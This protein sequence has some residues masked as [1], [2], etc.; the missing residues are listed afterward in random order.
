MKGNTKLLEVLNSLLADEL[1]AINQYIV[2][3]EMCADW[4]Y[5]KLHEHFEKRSKDEMRHA[6]KLIERLLFLEGI[7]IVSKL[8][9]IHIGSDVPKQLEYD[10]V[11]EMAAIKAYNDAIAL[12]GE[13]RDFATREILDKI[14]QDEDRHMDG[15][16]ELQGQIEHMTLPIF[17]T[18]KVE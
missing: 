14:L 6:E 10:R 1:A 18:T 15:I 5:E 12:A 9:N 3:A 4:G 8:S 7:P 2:H 11:A 13:V 16:E 17:L